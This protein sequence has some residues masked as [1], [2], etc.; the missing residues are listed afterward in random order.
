MVRPNTLQ[1]VGEAAVQHRVALGDE[2]H[3]LSLEQL[4][5]QLLGGGP[6][7]LSR[8]FRVVG[9]EANSHHPLATGVDELA[10]NSVGEAVLTGFRLGDADDGNFPQDSLR[11]QG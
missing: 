2:G 9:G 5:R 7:H 3:V 1:H 8:P 11:L 4:L 6:P 10:C